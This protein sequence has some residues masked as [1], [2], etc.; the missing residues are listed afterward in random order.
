[1]KLV[2]LRVKSKFLYPYA[3]LKRFYRLPHHTNNKVR[4]IEESMCVP[5][6]KKAPLRKF[7]LGNFQLHAQKLRC[8]EVFLSITFSLKAFCPK[9]VDARSHCHKFITNNQMAFPWHN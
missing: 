4:R 9:Q 7:P 8:L 5:N 3:L 1:M 6:I 2:P